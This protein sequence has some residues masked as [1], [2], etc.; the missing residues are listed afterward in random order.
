MLLQVSTNPAIPMVLRATR[1]FLV[2]EQEL[3]EGYLHYLIPEG[4]EWRVQELEGKSSFTLLPNDYNYLGHGDIIR[5]DGQAIRVLFR[6]NSRHNS[7]LVTEQCNH[8]CLMCS[9][10]PKN[11]DDSWILDELEA[12]IPLIPGETTEVGFSGGEPTLAGARFINLIRMMKSYLPRTVVHVLSNGRTFADE[13]FARQYAEVDHPDIMIGIPLYSDDPDLHDY[14][15]QAPGA[16]H[17]TVQGILN[18]K[19]LNQKVEIRIVLHK[20]SISRLPQLCEYIARN[21]LFVDHVTLMGLEMIGFTRA[22][23]EALWID[24]ADYRDVLSEAVGILAAYRMN[25]SV[26]NHQLCLVNDD[27]LPY[28]RKSISDWKNEYVP[29]CD[30]CARKS[31]CGGF[32]SSGVRN[33]YSRGITPFADDG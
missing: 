10:P 21:L 16:F 23:L 20:Q 3:P 11:I 2:S 5:L 29:E 24:P 31:E 12:L 9:Q 18:L 32:F 19:R 22:N 26:Y 15:V 1:A 6:A 13:S 7:L 14:I 17:E 28:Y 30:G 27:V 4:L 8:Y 33:G 25:V